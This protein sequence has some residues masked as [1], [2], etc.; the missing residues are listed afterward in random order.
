VKQLSCDVLRGDGF[1]QRHHFTA[2]A[3]VEAGALPGISESDVRQ[4]G[5]FD[6]GVAGAAGE[7][8]VE[9]CA[10]F[11]WRMVRL[12]GMQGDFEEIMEREDRE[13]L[14]GLMVREMA[15]KRQREEVEE[16]LSRTLLRRVLPGIAAL[17]V[18]REGCITIGQP[19]RYGCKFDSR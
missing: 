2:L 8:G 6:G 16:L 17:P 11:E 14:G 7:S 13:Q 4:R 12:P 19:L 5:G 10:V 15:W 18:V 1:G 3:V 9:D